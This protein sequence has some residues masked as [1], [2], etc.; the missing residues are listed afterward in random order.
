MNYPAASSGVSIGKYCNPPRRTGNF[1]LVRRR[2]IKK[3]K[4][5]PYRRPVNPPGRISRRGLR[6]PGK[7]FRPASARP[8]PSLSEATRKAGKNESNRVPSSG[9][10]NTG[11]ALYPHIL[12]LGTILRMQPE[13][14]GKYRGEKMTE[15]SRMLFGRDSGAEYRFSGVENGP[16]QE[17]LFDSGGRI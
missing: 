10:G 1:T 11:V 16:R 14:S 8:N 4:S 17:S 13:T 9:G 2:R 15:R 3:I 6:T 12:S 5:L 7:F